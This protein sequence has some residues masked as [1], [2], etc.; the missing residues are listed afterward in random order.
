MN[1]LKLHSLLIRLCLFFVLAYQTV[2][3]V[4]FTEDEKKWIASHPIIQ[5]SLQEISPKEQEEIQ[6][7][8][9]SFKFEKT[10]DYTLLYIILGVFF[11]FILASLLWYKKLRSEVVKRQESEEQMSMLIDNIPLNVI[12]SN[13]E[14][15]VLRANVFAL[16]TFNIKHEDIFAHNVMEFYVDSTQRDEVLKLIQREGKVTDKIVKFKRLD[17]TTMDVMLS[18]IPMMYDGQK[19]LLSI[20]VDLTQRIEMEE[21]L[22]AAKKTADN[23]NKSKSEFLAN[24]SHEIRTPMNAIMGFTE[25]LNEH[26]K[27]P[28]L[29]SYTKVI[30]N[31]GKSLLTL[32]NDILDLSKIEAG[33]LEIRKTAV[34]VHSIVND[35]ASIFSMTVAKKG[36]SIVTDI[37]E[38]IPKSLGIDGI[39][40][41]QVLVNLVGNAVKFT[42]EGY[43]KISVH[44]FNVDEHHSKLDLEI[45]VK[46]TGI[47]IAE[48]ERENI[49]N[50]FEQQEGQ[51]N[52]K[53]GGTGLGLSISKRLVEMMDGSILVQSV[54]KIG[55]TFFIYLYG[56][57]IS[58]IQL[59]ATDEAGE[60]KTDICFKPAKV[61]VV[62]DIED[63]RTLIVTNFTETAIEIV[64]ASDGLEAI[65][66]YKKEKPDLILMDIRMPNMDGYEATKQ[67]RAISDVPIIALTASIMVDEYEQTK[68]YGFSR[69]LRKPI[70]KKD[71]FVALSRFLEYEEVVTLDEHV[72]KNVLVLGES[73][74]Q[75]ISEVQAMLQTNI[76]PLYEKALG[77]NSIVD[78]QTFSGKVAKLAEKYKIMPLKEYVH[79]LNTAIDSFD[80]V[81]I[82]ALLKAFEHL[83]KELNSF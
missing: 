34:D 50:S 51:D 72:D 80:I 35:V 81:Q 71:L 13:F 45:S 19:A 52:R 16:E 17:E 28:R 7:K 6:D 73:A 43:I 1:L 42:E 32:I 47:G 3:A 53:F 82:Q 18:I 25:L 2:G 39:R 9:I 62:D 11:I 30:Q 63:N 60:E 54:E 21:R 37:D 74:M 58:T 20:M 29:K 79:T 64:T 36:L 57:D 8:W 48:G 56:V 26:V 70:L 83:S 69:Y 78:M 10:V 5:K 67:I 59:S 27:E 61:M 77:S 55:A 22:R 75:N 23:A 44:A 31:A 4:N 38:D 14:G 12:V 66:Q 24:M 40:L 49:F 76:L 65:E 33:K 41:R 15:S 46:D 68:G